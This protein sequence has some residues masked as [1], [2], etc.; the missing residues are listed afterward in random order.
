MDPPPFD[1]DALLPDPQVRVSHRR[2]AAADPATLW[3]AAGAVRLDETRTLG[4]LVR[5][6]IPGTPRDLTFR[7][8]LAAPPF[9]ILAEGERWSVSGLAGRIWTVRRDYPDLG[10]AEGFARWSQGGTVRVLFAHWV[11]PAGDGRSALT[12]EARVA[13]VDRAAAV[14]LRALWTVVGGWERL[15]GGEALSRAA[16]RAGDSCG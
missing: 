9:T 8:L 11:A 14:R 2:E 3:A 5:W 13:P 7:E 15:I 1:L 4:R 6:R 10:D 12:S 16:Q